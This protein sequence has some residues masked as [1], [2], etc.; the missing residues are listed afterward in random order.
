MNFFRKSLLALAVLCLVADASYAE[1]GGKPPLKSIVDMGTVPAKL[2]AKLQ[3]NFPPPSRDEVQTLAAPALTF[4]QVDYVYSQK[5]GSYEPVSGHQ[6][7]TVN[8]HGGSWLWII[9]DE[10]GY[11]DNP[12]ATWNGGQVSLAKNFVTQSICVNWARTGYD[13]PC[14]AGQTVVGFRKYWDFTGNES[15]VFTYQ[16]QSTNSPWNTMFDSMSIK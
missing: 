8:D 2:D 5:W 6:T 13:I 7:S 11:G 4:L 1:N 9:T 14:Q 10:L 3:K 16:N 15:G 12:V